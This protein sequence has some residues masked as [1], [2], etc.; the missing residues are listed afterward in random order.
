MKFGYDPARNA[1]NM[2]ERGHPG[3]VTAAGG[4]D[5]VHDIRREA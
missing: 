1:W 2:R 5:A 3:I 4:A